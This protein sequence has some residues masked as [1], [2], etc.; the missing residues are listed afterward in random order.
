MWAGSRAT[1]GATRGKV[2]FEVSVDA[3]ADASHL[4]NEDFPNVMRFGNDSFSR[5]F[6]AN[7]ISSHTIRMCVCRVGWSVDDAGLQL[8][9]EAFS[10][11]YG[12]TGKKSVNSLF[13]G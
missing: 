2:C 6:I 3:N 8:G 1:F 5:L 11:G 13:A 12:G 10:Y 4:T 9:E 7:I